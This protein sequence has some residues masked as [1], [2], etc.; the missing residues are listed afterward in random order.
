MGYVA[1]LGPE[2][3]ASF[4]PG[5]SGTPGVVAAGAVAWPPHQEHGGA[6]AMP[7]YG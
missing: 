5:V 4:Q 6:E 3:Q 1:Q 2:A 7:F